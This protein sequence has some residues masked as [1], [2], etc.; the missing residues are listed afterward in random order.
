MQQTQDK[1][2]LPPGLLDPTELALLASHVAITLDAGVRGR[3][4]NP[5]PVRAL[6]AILAKGLG[7]SIEGSAAGQAKLADPETTALLTRA[8]ATGTKS[9]AVSEIGEVQ[10]AAQAFVNASSRDLSTLDQETLA[11]LRDFALG[12]SLA[13]RTPQSISPLGVPRL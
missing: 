4:V 2:A 10:A 3:T 9:V 12:V 1:I 7:Q 13:A 8:L 6:G 5:A 11:A